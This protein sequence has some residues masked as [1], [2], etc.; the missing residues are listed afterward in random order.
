M[1]NPDMSHL[2]N[3]HEEKLTVGQGKLFNIYVCLELCVRA[4]GHTQ[5]NG[6]DP[7]VDEINVAGVKEEDKSGKTANTEALL[8]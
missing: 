7:P 2:I 4:P 1:Y 6:L 8:K 5:R 3:F